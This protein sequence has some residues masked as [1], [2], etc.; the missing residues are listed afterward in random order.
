MPPS[1][2]TVHLNASTLLCHTVCTHTQAILLFDDIEAGAEFYFTED[3]H[4]RSDEPSSAATRS[5]RCTLGKRRH[6]QKIRIRAATECAIKKR[7]ERLAEALGI[8]RDK[9]KVGV[10]AGEV[11]YP[12]ELVSF[13][14]MNGKFVGLVEQAFEE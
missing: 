11:V 13:G 14:R 1:R 3:D 7:N 2:V 10:G 6:H 9:D 8:S 12:D 4:L 5:S